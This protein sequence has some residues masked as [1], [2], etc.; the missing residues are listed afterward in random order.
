M[1]PLRDR[2][3]RETARQEA[4]EL[5]ERKRKNL[6]VDYKA[7]RT[8]FYPLLH[9]CLVSGSTHLLRCVGLAAANL[10]EGTALLC[11]LVAWL[12]ASAFRS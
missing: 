7:S 12:C 2:R 4:L 8:I 5:L 3:R 6:P 9:A 11:Y 10:M 1:L